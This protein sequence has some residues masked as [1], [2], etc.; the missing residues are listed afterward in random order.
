M[1]TARWYA[2][3]LHSKAKPLKIV[4]RAGLE[5]DLLDLYTFR[6]Q[7]SREAVYLTVPAFNLLLPDWIDH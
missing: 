4:D 2:T 6:L 3:L 1:M 7:Q 5:Y